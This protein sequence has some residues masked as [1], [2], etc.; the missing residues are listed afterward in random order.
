MKRFLI[1]NIIALSALGCRSPGE[2]DQKRSPAFDA[3]APP[4]ARGADSGATANG[5]DRRAVRNVI[6]LSIDSLRSDMPWTGYP[7]AIAPRIT[8][9]AKRSVVY[10]H[11]YAVSSYTSMS[12]GGMLAGRY[13][14]ELKRNGYFFGTYAKENLFFPEL[15]QAAHV[16]T[17]GA[18]AHG[19]FKDAGLEQGFDRWEIVPNLKWNNTTD[20]NV[21]SP[22]HEAIAEKLL[23][24]VGDGPFFAWFH[25]LDPHDQYI[26]HEKDGIPPF[27]N[28]P[29]DRYDAEVLF[30]DRYV[31]KLLDFISEKP[32]ANETAILLT[33]D[34][35]EAFGEHG[36]SAHGFELWENLVRVPLLVNLPGNAARVID[37]PRSAID[38]APTILSLLHVPPDPAFA[39]VDLSPEWY[40]APALPRDV[41]LDLPMTS[42][43]DRR[44]AFL[45]GT[46]KVIGFG[47]DN[48]T[49][50]FDLAADPGELS[51]L[52]SD[53]TTQEIVKR[54][55]EASKRVKDIPPT[56][57]NVGCL[58]GAYAKP[59]EA[60][61]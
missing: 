25:F 12:L 36:Q 48:L 39:G 19:Y 56:Q 14:A 16:K 2:S 51:P 32:W 26:S 41:M 42:D 13:P 18:H 29:R 47:T 34:H 55:Q 22:A 60:S 50:V 11:A 24:E 58:N 35:G 23:S 3:V 59:K 5:R 17:V 49:K 28:Q 6:L 4:D 52:K 20:E 30:T 9:F 10:T 1:L 45:S 54:F 61:P 7:R 37:T 44:R 27:G 8:E 31:G 15:L 40:G 46:K 38:L 57:C 21:T 53:E 43:N 33:A